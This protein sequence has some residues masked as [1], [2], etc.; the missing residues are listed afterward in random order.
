MHLRS[1]GRK[2]TLLCSTVNYRNYFVIFLDV[3]NLLKGSPRGEL[4]PKVGERGALSVIFR[5]WKM[6]PL[7]KGEAKVVWT[8]ENNFKKREYKTEKRI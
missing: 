8:L 5:F 2:Q 7:P 6:T 4:T 3:V 1:G